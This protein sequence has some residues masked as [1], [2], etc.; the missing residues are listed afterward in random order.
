MAR[1]ALRGALGR[2]LGM[3]GTT[4]RADDL[5]IVGLMGRDFFPPLGS[6]SYP[7]AS[8]KSH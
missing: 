4:P 8:G 5:W 2:S 7:R 6:K 1:P 3:Q